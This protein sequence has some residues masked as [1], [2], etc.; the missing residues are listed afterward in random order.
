VDSGDTIRVPGAGSGGRGS[1]P[2]SLFIKLKAQF[3]L[4]IVS[5]YFW[6]DCLSVEDCAIATSYLSL[7]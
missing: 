7:S 6:I 2:G 4:F 1:Q 5:P 3:Y